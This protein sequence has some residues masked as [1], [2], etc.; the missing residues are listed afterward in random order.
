MKFSIT[1]ALLF[2]VFTVVAQPKPGDIFREYTW[3]TPGDEKSEPFLR[4]CG[5]GFYFDATRKGEELFPDGFIKD[6]WFTLP[7]NID[8]TDAIRAEV[9]VERMLCHDGTTGLAVKFN[10]G[11]WHTL[12]D[13]SNIPQPQSEYLYHYYPIVSLPLN[14]LRNGDNANKFRF[15]VKEGQRFGMPQNMVYGMVVRV[16]YKNSKPHADAEISTVKNGDTL[17]EKVTLNVKSK[18]P[19]TKVEYIGLMEDINYEGDGNYYQW[20]YNY[21]RGELQN[22][23]GTS[24][25]GELTWN[26][27]W[28][29]DQTN[30]IQ[31]AARVTNADGVIYMTKAIEN[32]QLKRP[33]NVELCKPYNIP[34]RWATREMEFVQAFDVKG[35]LTKVEKFLVTAVT[36]SPGYLNGVYLNDFLIMDRESCKYCYHI[37]RREYTEK[38]YLSS[39]NGLKTGKTPFYHGKMQHGTEIQYPGFMVLVKY[40]KE[41]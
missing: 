10:N 20:H 1:I 5:D 22:H 29:P 40:K 31:I 34:K 23:I 25:S 7:Q 33:F 15:T 41:E 14:E 17:G 9:L 11:N 27:E 21:H 39:M 8:L 35:D 6:G 18:S 28:V 2:L 3:A 37:I 12:P 16:Y 38:A 13:A 32:L 19:F 26:T 36:W 30:P 4:V 24:T